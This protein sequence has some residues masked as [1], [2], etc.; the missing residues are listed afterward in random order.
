MHMSHGICNV[1]LVIAESFNFSHF[2]VSIIRQPAQAFFVLLVAPGLQR[3]S[4]TRRSRRCWLPQRWVFLFPLSN[5]YTLS[6]FLVLVMP[7]DAL[8]PR[9]SSS[10]IVCPDPP[11]CNCA[12]NQDCFQIN[13]LELILYLAVLYLN[14][15]ILGIAPLVAHSNALP[16]TVAPQTIDNQVLLARVLAKVPLLAL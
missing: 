1:V 11:P 2:G 6:L 12:A 7:L 3:R 14:V 8:L 9:Q 4:C 13:R 5:S 10:C 16:R 15:Y